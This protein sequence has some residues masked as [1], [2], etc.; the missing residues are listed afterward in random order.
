[1]HE[2]IERLPKP[3][4]AAVVVCYL[5][6]MSQAQAARQFDL[7]E[8]TVRGRLARARKLLGQRLTRRGIAPSLGTAALGNS[9]HAAWRLPGMMAQT[10]AQAALL[11][12][13]RGKTTPGALS[14]TA[15]GIAQG[16]LST[17]WPSSLK[18]IAAVTMAGG[19]LTGGAVLLSQPV[20]E[21]QHQDQPS[22]AEGALEIKVA[23]LKPAHD[24]GT[25]WATSAQPTGQSESQKDQSTA[26]N[27]DLVKLVP[28]PIVRA[29][30]VSKDCMVLAYLPDWNFGNVDNIGIGNNDGGVRTLIDWP[31]IPPDEALSPEKQYLVALYS[32]KTI[33]HPPAGMILAFEI[34]EEWPERTSW[35][36]QPRYDGEPVVTYKFEPGGGWKLF[37][38]T[39]LV[40]ARAKAS[41]NGHG[42]LLRFLNEEVSGGPKEVFSDYKIVSRE[43]TDEWADR[44]PLLLVVKASKPGKSPSN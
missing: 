25:D 22:Q 1:L 2:E 29:V 6:G 35:R 20:V 28:G 9:T 44:R 32:R 34:L 40:R 4:R 11:F 7:A 24:T 37:D 27:P 33:H 21:A 31:A 38:I 18:T 3:Y 8:S 16:V 10:T 15:Q 13:K 14:A 23:S 5:E 17:M 19:L 41:R 42:I 43:G 36:T 12:V 39:P 26:V 30:S